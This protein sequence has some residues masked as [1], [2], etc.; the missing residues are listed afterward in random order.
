MSKPINPNE[1]GPLKRQTFPD[2]VFDAF[3]ELIAADYS[4]GSARVDQNKVIQLILEKWNVPYKDEDAPNY[5][6]QIFDNG[7]LNVEEA[8][9]AEGWKVEYDKPGYNESYGAYF[10]FKKK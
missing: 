9:E 10:K 4:N 5:R 2:F 1:I 3:N 8:Y 7:W 6:Q